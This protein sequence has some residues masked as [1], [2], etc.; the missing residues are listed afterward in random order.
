MIST[1]A[2]IP[3]YALKNPTT[4]A[5]LPTPG[6]P[7][8]FQTNFDYQLVRAMGAEAYSGSSIGECLVTAKRIVDGD[9]ESFV[10]AWSAMAVRVEQLGDDSFKGG[11]L[12]S[13]REAFLRA[14][15]YWKTAGFFL[16][17]ADPRQM[18]TW[19]KSRECF[20]KAGALFDPVIEPIMIPYEDGKFLPGYFMKADATSK[21]RPTVMIM[22][23][24]D[25]TG[26]ELYFFGGGAAAVRR[27]YNALLFEG[28]G[29]RGT[30]YLDSSLPYRPDWEVPMKYV[31][32]YVLTR[33]EVDP[34]RLALIGYSMGGYFAPRAAAF[35]KRIKAVIANS[36]APDMRVLL[37][38][39]G[40]DPNKSYEGQ[41]IE[42]LVDLTD[43]FRRFG[44]GDF[45]WRCG[46]SDVPL[47]K[48]VAFIGTFSLKGLERMI[49]C[50]LLNICGNGEGQMMLQASR[51]FYDQLACPKAMYC[52]E[53]DEG[54]EAHCQVN[55]PSRAHQITFDWLDD[56][57]GRTH[58]RA[59]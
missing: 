51:K 16:G 25:T 22:G 48:L 42:S 57:F 32:D 31:L 36:L 7:G 45:R 58:Q 11:H 9:D 3:G 52:L 18:A 21:P 8:Y 10:T 33:P 20:Q 30:M 15:T 55:N 24:G 26:E 34:E 46:L 19:K 5:F 6:M 35:E 53:D 56:V 14:C 23:G 47:S 49:T 59:Q 12:V 44:V 38:I 41:D 37:A 29:Q 28:P 43:P 17:H 13:A 4:V 2:A 27:G 50:P 54:A 1:T 40:L 39:L